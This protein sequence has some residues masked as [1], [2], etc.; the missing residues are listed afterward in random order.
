MLACVYALGFLLLAPESASAPSPAST[1]APSPPADSDSAQTKATPPRLSLG[2]FADPFGR[3]RLPPGASEK[4]R[5]APWF[6]DYIEVH[7]PAP[8]TFQEIAA[9]LWKTWDIP[10][11]PG[12]PMGVPSHQ[13]MMEH[14]P[15][16]PP[17]SASIIDLAS[18]FMMLL[19]QRSLRSQPMPPVERLPPPPP[20]PELRV[21]L[22]AAA[23]SPG[24]M[25]SPSPTP[26][27]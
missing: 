27:P 2:I 3:V 15:G 22:R 11:S 21:E 5:I 10:R 8:K 4:E 18:Y 1:P 20:A 24:P 6:E 12:P 7:A 17:P 23:P 25:S 16:T 19:A 9:D 14:M 26:T 13:E